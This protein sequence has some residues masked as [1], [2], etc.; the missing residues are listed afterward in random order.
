MANSKA[1]SPTLPNETVELMAEIDGS[2]VLIRILV[3]DLPAGMQFDDGYFISTD[4]GSLLS[5]ALGWM[6]E[7]VLRV[8][9]LEL[10]LIGR[11]AKRGD[12]PIHLLPREFELL[13]YM[14]RRSNRLLTRATLFK[15]V[16]HYKFAP[17][18]NLV[19]VHMG[20]LRRKIDGS[21]DAPMIRTVR[22]EGFVL[23]ASASCIIRLDGDVGTA[24]SF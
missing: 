3:G 1:T 6:A 14:M 5:S 24:S 21:N 11:A 23:S 19:D 12:R 18:T 9:S 22:G 4:I 20:R 8:G 7:T 10:D 2:P 15:E 17:D 13:R 16:W